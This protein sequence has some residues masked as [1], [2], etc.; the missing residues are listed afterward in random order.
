MYV[1]SL[2]T[3]AI[4]VS[5]VTAYANSALLNAGPVVDLAYSVRASPP[6]VCR[7]VALICPSYPSQRFVG[8]ETLPGVAFYGAIP[9]A[10]PPLGDL[11]WRSP[12]Q[13]DER[14][15]AETDRPVY[16]AR[17]FG[18]ICIQQPAVVGIG[19]EG[20]Y[21]IFVCLVTGQELTTRWARLRDS[22]HL[23]TNQRDKRQQIAGRCLHTWASSTLKPVQRNK[24]SAD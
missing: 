4:L 16:D 11:R 3:A 12:Q 8:N 6:D 13:L 17:N 24:P 10:R 15:I 2:L 1:F 5:Q 18:Q 20:I 19:S 21:S 14:H 9:Y 7:T 22:Q 23:E